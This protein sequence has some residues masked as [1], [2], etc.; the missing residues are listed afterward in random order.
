M[1]P[2]QCEFYALEGLSH[3]LRTYQAM[4]RNFNKDL[5]IVKK[6]EEKYGKIDSNISKINNSIKDINDKI[7][8]EEKNKPKKEQ[9]Y[10]I[11]KNQS[12]SCCLRFLFF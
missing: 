8:K 12:S 10:A 11:F 9:S 3:L 1:I 7:A 4:K 2:I 5:E 6:N